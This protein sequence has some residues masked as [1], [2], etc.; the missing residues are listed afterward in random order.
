MH[1]DIIVKTAVRQV[2]DAS[3]KVVEEEIKGRV[4]AVA[5]RSA[6]EM[7]GGLGL[8]DGGR[9][10]RFMLDNNSGVWNTNAA[11]PVGHI[12]NDEVEKQDG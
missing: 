6:D 9:V 1:G 2:V 3:G 11:N 7:V 5:S 4:D 12:W 10:G 8:P